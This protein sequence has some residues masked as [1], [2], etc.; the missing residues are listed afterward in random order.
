[1]R[2]KRGFTL[3]ELVFGTILLSSL[4]SVFV[5]AVRWGKNSL[6]QTDKAVLLTRFRNASYLISRDLSCAT[7]FMF[8]NKIESTGANLLVFKNLDNEIMGMY[9][10]NDGLMLY[11]HTKD[12]EKLLFPYVEKFQARLV[13]DNLVEYKIDFKKDKLAFSVRNWLT[14]Y[15]SLP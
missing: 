14:P 7:D 8:P 1:M 15:N 2:R 13:Q 5:L 9:L 3:V 11:N 6:D 10:G 12:V 4:L